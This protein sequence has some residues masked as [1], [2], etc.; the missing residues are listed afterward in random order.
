MHPRPH[1]GAAQTVPRRALPPQQCQVTLPGKP[2]ARLLSPIV[3][4]LLS[5][6]WEASFTT[7]GSGREL[8]CV[9]TPSDPQGEAPACCLCSSASG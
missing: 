7:T 1:M 2:G 8:L 3:L 6:A 5:W 9:D 4:L